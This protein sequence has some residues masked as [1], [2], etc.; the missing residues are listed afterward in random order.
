M[1]LLFIKQPIIVII[2][3]AAILITGLIIVKDFGISTDEHL[4]HRYGEM[5][6]KY[7]VKGEKRLLT[8][9]DRYYGPAFEMALILAENIILARD[10]AKIFKL[11]HTL[12]FLTYFIGLLFFFMLVSK[13]LQDW[14]WGLLGAIMLVLTPRITGHAF[15]NSK[16]IPILVFSI[17]SMFTLFKF[18]ETRTIKWAILHGLACAVAIDIRILGVLMVGLTLVKCTGDFIFVDKLKN[19]KK[20]LLLVG[21]YL[22]VLFTGIYAMWPTLWKNPL[23]EFSQAYLQMKKFH[24]DHDVLYLG[25]YVRSTNLPWHYA[26]VWMA[27]TIPV[28]YIALFGTA[29]V[30]VAR[31]TFVILKKNGSSPY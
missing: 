27:I 18:T 29:I 25:Q 10:K 22:V 20:F 24:W 14:R 1:K 4:Q 28:I 30:K 23:H 17:I 11:R 16:D 9:P 7:V 19:S 12:N 3:F 6:W 26:L 2:T 5:T 15:Y 21:L 8:Y 13:H 31:D